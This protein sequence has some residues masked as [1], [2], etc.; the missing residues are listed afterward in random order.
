MVSAALATA[1]AGDWVTYEG[2]EG[3]GNGKHIVLISGDE[4]YRSEEALPML[5]KI[6]SQHHGYRCTVL[7][8]VDKNSG[9]IN[10]NEQTNIPGMENVSSADLVIMALRFRELPDKDMK[11]FVEYLMAGKPMIALR[12]STHA[13]QYSRNTGSP[14]AKFD[15]R[16]KD[17]PG[18]FGQQLLGETWLNHHGHH[19]AESARG[20]ID[21]VN[22]DHPILRGVKDVWGDSDVYGVKR[23]PSSAT[24]LMHGLTLSGMQPD[25]PPN[26]DK[27]LMPMIWLKDYQV[28]GG[29][30]GQ[31]L[32]STI[33]AA[34]DLASADLRRLMVNAAYWFTGLKDKIDGK[35]NVDYVGEYK[36]T[37]FSF[38]GYVKGVKPA[39]HELKP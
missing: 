28:P 38:N 14:Y 31:G 29:K 4:E 23:L 25:S 17:W 27:A 35:A 13:F 10:P 19:K 22:K 24:V 33:G 5:G 6:L 21:G 34:T 9:E 20:L 26:Y 18:G 30:T 2:K 3:P 15:W 37:A 7:F 32:T 8:P 11:H 39:D 16:N 36:P 1:G 12:T